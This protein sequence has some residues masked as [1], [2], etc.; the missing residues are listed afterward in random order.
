[1]G[2]D[3]CEHVQTEI[4]LKAL[5]KD[6]IYDTGYHAQRHAHLI[7]EEEYF[8][9]RA[10]ASA[11]LYFSY[12][13]RSKRIFEYG[14]GIGQGIASLPNASG[15]DVSTEAREHCRRRNLTVYDNIDM[16]PRK[17]WDIVFCRHVLEH[18]ENPLEHLKLMRELIVESGELFLVLPRERH[19]DSSFAPDLNQHLFCWNFRAINN[20]L[21]RAGLR[22]TMNRCAYVLG[23]RV[24]L[25]VRRTLGASAYYYATL[26]TGYLKRNGEL[27]VRARVN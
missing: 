5:D 14:C 13:E 23:Y 2:N 25:P 24:L 27:I 21:Q 26:I 22:P 11:R 17:A 15:W 20:L 1:L 6:P 4:E 7:A 19:Y 3:C 8:W 16:V 12:G 18:L 10:E 9:A